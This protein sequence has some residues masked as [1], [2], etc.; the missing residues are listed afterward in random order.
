[1]VNLG[2]RYVLQGSFLPLVEGAGWQQTQQGAYHDSWQLLLCFCLYPHLRIFCWTSKEAPRSEICPLRLN[3]FPKA[4]ACYFVAVSLIFKCARFHI[5]EVSGSGVW[6]PRPLPS[7]SVTPDPWGSGTFSSQRLCLRLAVSQFHSFSASTAVFPPSQSFCPLQMSLG[8]SPPTRAVQTRTTIRDT[9]CCL[10]RSNQD[11]SCPWCEAVLPDTS[12]SAS[13]PLHFAA[14][15]FLGVSCPWKSLTLS[16]SLYLQAGH[17]P[18]QLLCSIS[19]CCF[20]LSLTS[21]HVFLW[22][23]PAT[24]PLSGA[25]PGKWQ[26]II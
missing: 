10:C 20:C 26:C 22:G 9:G 3:L 5:T 23:R 25:L 4:G 11:L 7:V 21:P 19:S 13:R 18:P 12:V 24:T 2:K 8:L 14:V 1:M 16:L 15:S 6:L 17:L